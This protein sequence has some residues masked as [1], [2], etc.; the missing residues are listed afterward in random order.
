MRAIEHHMIMKKRAIGLDNK[1]KPNYNLIRIVK[2]TWINDAADLPAPA[3]A[4]IGTKRCG[5]A[6][7]KISIP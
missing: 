2:V 7:V 4:P 1:V 3:T 5:K 6:G